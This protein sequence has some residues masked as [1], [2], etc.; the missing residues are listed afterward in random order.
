MSAH[1]KAASELAPCPFCDGA[2]RMR[3]RSGVTGRV[4]RSRYYREHV[5]CE[6]CGAQGPEGNAP[7]V[8]VA[9]WNKLARRTGYDPLPKPPVTP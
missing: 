2:V 8:T 3:R 7:N 9:R 5:K 6:T 4:C 1:E